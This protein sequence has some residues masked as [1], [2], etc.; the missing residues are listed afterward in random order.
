[1]FDVGI[2]LGELCFSHASS[3]LKV[4]Y[5]GFHR[6]FVYA[7][8]P[9]GLNLARLKCIMLLIFAIYVMCMVIDFG[10]VCFGATENHV[11]KEIHSK[12]DML[13]FVFPMLCK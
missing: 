5:E 12:H 10:H 4:V 2:H 7:W 11:K 3:L 1:M 13:S 8:E 9:S 6:L